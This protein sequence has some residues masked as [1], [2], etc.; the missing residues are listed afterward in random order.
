MH[1]V[2]LVN[3]TDK[4]ITE[5][6]Q[7]L[8]A[9]GYVVLPV[10]ATSR[11]LSEAIKQQKPDIVIVDTESPSRDT[12][13]QL[14]LMHTSAPRPVVM[15]SHDADQQLIRAAVGAG[16]TTYVVDGL[17]PE[18]LAP[19]LAVALARFA[20]ESKLRQRLASV[21]KELADRKLIDRAK[22]L[23]MDKRQMSEAQAYETLRNQAMKQG[24]K[25]ADIA[26]QII[27]MADLLN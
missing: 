14:A 17:A 7:A 23:L 10:V 1:R 5:L 11:A 9:H 2:L 27:A 13:E 20:E 6:C 22:G 18:R 12:L 24:A 19:I 21:E 26:R 3:D 15:F 16:V 4:P 8:T 25:I